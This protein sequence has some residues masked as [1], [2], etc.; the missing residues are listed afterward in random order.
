MTAT[1]FPPAEGR[2]W[3]AGCA[4]IRR[5][6]LFVYAAMLVVGISGVTDGTYPLPLLTEARTAELAAALDA[7]GQAPLDYVVRTFADHDAVF[8]GEVHCI[9]HVGQFVQDLLPRLHEAGV[10]VLA[11]ELARREDQPLVDELL[12]SPV[13]DESLA[14]EIVFRQYLHHGL[15]EYVDVFRAAWELNA[16]LAPSEPR[17]RIVGVND[18][19]DWSIVRTLA[20]RDDAAVERAVWRGQSERDW[21]DV[22]LRE[23]EAGEKVLVY[24]GIHHAFTAYV[25]PVA[26]A[27][28]GEF[29]PP[30]PRRMGNYVYAE[31]GERAYTIAL[32]APWLD[33][34]GRSLS[35]YAAGGV[36]DALMSTLGPGAYPIGFDT[37]GTLFGDIGVPESCLYAQGRDALTLGDW[38]DGYVFH[39]P[40]HHFEGM[41]VIPDFVTAANVERARRI[42]WDPRFRDATPAE[43]QWSILGEASVEF[44]LRA[45]R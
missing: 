23:V 33:R 28:T 42:T 38:C 40:L 18:S 15:R 16:S 9:A 26:D 27:R 2:A 32:H 1:S 19:P 35:E 7:E 31:I 41:T 24:C 21:A 3:I 5:G 11:T 34:T 30:F 22:V 37:R 44:R 12:A 4:A 25:M 45:F 14:R 10:N 39:R 36:I 6:I 43:F 8:L 13:Y 17:F 20:D 29:R